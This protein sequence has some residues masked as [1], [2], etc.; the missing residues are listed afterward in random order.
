MQQSSKKAP[1]AG[2]GIL[3]ISLLLFSFFFANILVGKANVSFHW[4]LP[5]LGSL[6][7]FLLLGAA[8]TTFIW[9]ALRREAAEKDVTN[10]TSKEA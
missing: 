2:K 7:E 4:G 10:T 9:S 6:A 5:H 8:S 3:R 1:I